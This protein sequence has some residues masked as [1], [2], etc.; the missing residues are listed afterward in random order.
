MTSRQTAFA[1]FAFGPLLLAGLVLGSTPDNNRSDAY[2]VRY[3]SDNGHDLRLVVSG[4][5]LVL[6]ALAWIPFSTG[7]RE[8]G[9]ASRAAAGF[10]ALAAAAVSI[11]G[12]LT[13]LVPALALEGNHYVPDADVLRFMSEIGYSVLAFNGLLAAGVALA[14]IVRAGGLPRPLAVTAYAVC[15]LQIAAVF[16]LPMVLFG[17]WAIAAAIVLVRRPLH[18]PAAVG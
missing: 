18:I 12:T 9:G 2:W 15:V 8:R 1:G 16:F 4:L 7:L 6:A 14:L 3:F 5:A 10:A 11:G 13:S 17:V